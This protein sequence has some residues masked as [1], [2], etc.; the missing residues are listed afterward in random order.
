VEGFNLADQALAG[1]R[2]LDFTR[3]L[4]GPFCTMLMGDM[5]ADVIKVENPTRGDDTRQWG[6]PW[7][8]EGDQAQSAYFL[9]VNRSKRSLT[10]NLKTEAGQSLAR[11]LA[12]GSHIVVENFK[13]GEMARFGL[14]YEA[15]RQINP[16]LV[17]CSITGFGQTGPYRDYPGYDYA[18]QAMSG[19]MSITGPEDGGSYKVGVAI[20]DVLTGLFASTSILAALRHAESTGVGQYIDI[21]LLDSQ[22]AALVNIAS[23]Y[24]VSGQPP[25]RF[26]NQHPNIVPY[27]TFQAADGDF[28]VAVGND[29]QFAQQCA[30]LGCSELAADPRYATN[31]ARVAHR[32]SL[33]PALQAFF[34]QRPAMD[35]V[36]DLLAI[37]I[38]AAPINDI[39][40]I[41]NDPQV[42]ARGLVYAEF[43]GPPMQFSA[44]P[45]QVRLP[46]PRLGQHT[47]EVLREYLGLDDK[48][49]NDY[50][51]AGVL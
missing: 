25:Q 50:H 6:P 23:N 19:L 31:P 4:A 9:S 35:W 49:I 44:T 37:G 5:G 34:N 38:P 43:I 3:V 48:Q 11:Q 12:G 29:R 26:G 13:P 14:D 15:L 46:P 16:A 10:L 51:T 39:P 42:Q 21:A 27:Q 7:S 36:K 32:D 20:S 30:L 22:I 17:Y 2:V 41:L 47:D 45:A 24:L 18:I 28:V 40:T 33:I 8:G 1:V